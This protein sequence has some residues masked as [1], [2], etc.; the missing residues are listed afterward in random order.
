MYKN[1]LGVLGVGACEERGEEA[2][3]KGGVDL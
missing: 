1:V 3:V 2:S